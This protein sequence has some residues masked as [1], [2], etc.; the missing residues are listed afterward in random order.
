[1][2]TD[3]Q[4]RAL[5]YMILRSRE[6]KLYENSMAKKILA[7]LIDNSDHMNRDV[8]LT[9]TE[10]QEGYT[11]D[12]IEDTAYR[13]FDMISKQGHTHI[14]QLLILMGVNMRFSYHY[15]DFD[16]YRIDNQFSTTGQF[17]GCDPSEVLD[18][19]SIKPGMPLRYTFWLAEKDYS[20]D[21]HLLTPTRK[22]L[23]TTD[24]V[25]PSLYLLLNAE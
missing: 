5:K 3:L 9:L 14:N 19:D 11:R 24:L 8:C 6:D 21:A 15:G 23:E 18:L 16:P 22:E 4:I 2:V 25:I 12:E 1:M 13:M 10:N 17:A 20:L 7:F